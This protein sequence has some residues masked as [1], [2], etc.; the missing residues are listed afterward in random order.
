[1]T[2]V[3]QIKADAS[4]FTTTVD[5]AA[6]K[7]TGLERK[8]TQA[9]DALTRSFRGVAD[10]MRWEGLQA[11]AKAFDGL[12]EAIRREQNMLEKINGPMQRYEQ[13]LQTL[14]ALLNKDKISTEQYAEQVRRLNQELERGSTIKMTQAAPTDWTANI[15]EFR[16]IG[17]EG[18]GGES[19]NMLSKLGTKVGGLGGAGLLMAG[20]EAFAA[21]EAIRGLRELS[22]GYTEIG[23]KLRVV[24][25]GQDDWNKLMSETRGIADDTR[26]SW[27]ATVSTYQRL[28]NV[29]GELKNANGTLGLSE[30]QVLDLTKQINE[31]AK[32]S[33][34]SQYESMMA[35]M[36]LTHAFAMGSLQGRQFMVLLR[37]MPAMM[38]ELQVAS[39]L[40]QSQFAELGHQGKI[41][42]ADLVQWFGAAAPAIQNKFDKTKSTWSEMWT[43]MKNDTTAGVGYIGD[44]FKTIGGWGETA[45]LAADN[46]LN[47]Y[48]FHIKSLSDH[49]AMMDVYRE[50]TEKLTAATSQMNTAVDKINQAMRAG[51]DADYD[52]YGIFKGTVEVM[53]TGASVTETVGSALDYMDRELVKILGPLHQAK[54][55]L[56]AADDQMKSLNTQAEA[57][58]NVIESLN[59]LM[60]KIRPMD[61]TL[62]TNPQQ[63]AYLQAREAQIKAE[64]AI[65]G[66]GAA[67]DE[68]RIKEL[69]RSVAI[70]GL[71]KAVRD[72]IIST[73]DYEH[74]LKTLMDPADKVTK[75]IHKLTAEE[76]EEKR[77]LEGLAGA[78]DK[79]NLGME[80]SFDLF[81]KGTIS[82]DQ[83]KIAVLQLQKTYDEAAKSQ[84]QLLL[85][86]Q[87][88]ITGILGFVPQV[89]AG[90]ASLPGLPEQQQN[91]KNLTEQWRKELS[92]FQAEAKKTGQALQ[93]LFDPLVSAVDNF[94]KTGNF[95]I[96]QLGGQIL[97]MFEQMILKAL[98]FK[99]ISAIIGVPYGGGGAGGLASLLGFATG[100]D[101]TIPHAANGLSGTFGGSGGTDSQL[102]MARVTPGEHVSIRTPEQMAA[103]QQQTARPV[104]V[105]VHDG[106]DPRAITAAFASPDFERQVI[107]IVRKNRLN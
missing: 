99:A 33:G 77:I 61:V 84:A 52:Y 43:T 59:N 6:D 79:F 100:G 74:Q 17:A 39:G 101:V 25:S 31:A 66:Y 93:Q 78:R 86:S 48:I 19:G 27:D 23:N 10:A 51:R 72:S 56:K 82:L 15:K 41:T 105:V 34:A 94:F 68:I 13:S 91:P 96:K 1:M 4:G 9:G 107:R 37:D 97:D 44:Q 36:E 90:P 87:G 22:D 95:D 85:E 70:Q 12:T 63:N 102:F 60:A 24:A 30:Q 26:M 69:E 92:A 8:G 46:A 57:A 38:H 83:Y 32:I 98:E 21:V 62:L 29:T 64:D 54:D 73:K 11:G 42:A 106:G 2:F 40:S 71:S 65:H 45:F 89:G 88:G 58:A 7:L 104:H 18:G 49:L 16:G 80:A 55:A 28:K 75:H 50:E 14:D 35:T 47:H 76:Q 5:Q 67:T 53:R 3:A 20:G 81:A 103:A